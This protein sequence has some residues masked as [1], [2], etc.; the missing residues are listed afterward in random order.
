[1]KNQME[2]NKRK[3]RLII[4]IISIITLMLVIGISYAYFY[5][6]YLGN[7]NLI[8]AES[9]E[10]EFLESDGEIINLNNA[11]PIS[12]KEGKEQ[13]ETFDFQ[14]KT[15]TK[16]SANII[17]GLYIEK[18]ETGEGYETLKDDEIKLYLTDFSNN[19]K[20]S[21]TKVSELND[22]MLY[23]ETN[24]HNN[25]NIEQKDKYKL[26]MWID[27]DTNTE[28]WNENANLQYKIKIGVKTL[29]NL[30]ISGANAPVL[31]DNMIPVYYD[32]NTW[33]KADSTNENSDY[34]WYDYNNKM[35]ANS[36]TVSSTNRDTYK[37]ANPGTEI[38]MDEILT[39]QV[40]IPRYT[41]TVWNY[42]LDGTV[43]S[44]PQEI[45]IEFEKGTSSNGEITCEDNVQGT[46]DGTASGTKATVSEVC[47]IDETECTDSIC[48]GKT[49]T[50][51]AFT[52]GDEELEGFWI[53]KFE[54]TGTAE[55]ITTKPNLKAFDSGKV[56][57]FDNYLRGLNN[58]GNIYG[59]STFDDTHM[60]KNLEWGAV[61]Y[62]SHSK[63]GVNKEVEIN[64]YIHTMTGCGP[65]SKG[66]TDTGSTCN[67][68]NTTLGQ[69]ASTTGN[70]YGV[71]DM[72]GGLNEHVMGNIVSPD[73]TRMM[74]GYSSSYHSGY[75]GIVYDKG[76][77]TP[78]EGTYKY[79]EDKYIDKYSFN[80]NSSSIYGSKLGDGIKEVL[81]TSSEAWYNDNL[82]FPASS[83]GVWIK[84]GGYNYWTGS[85][86]GIFS[87]FVSDGMSSTSMN[88]KTSRLVIS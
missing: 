17:Y 84:R 59:F 24:I 86:L 85:Y 33:R 19:E 54:L 10:I 46:S 5:Y 25:A 45:Q 68:Y 81:N 61:A 80:T 67:A 53:G 64:S 15:K 58:S 52:F 83:R 51:P 3:K 44:E 41:Y 4:A 39:M 26:R 38:P 22:H 12:D 42:N 30:D 72:A 56:S 35:W 2:N 27:K 82:E 48:N 78:Y 74:S 36:V 28:N 65:V 79:P 88:C 73:G 75:T 18:L 87:L 47:Y 11:L 49:Y 20:V 63:Y 8:N 50:H 71:Y 43:T 55:T 34:R 37:S 21:P 13:T 29:K 16:K 1:M 60:I 6:G 40:W 31:S 57:D 62:L 66:S 14:V 70:V 69:S 76:N 77:Y 7:N 32:G 23:I 9:I